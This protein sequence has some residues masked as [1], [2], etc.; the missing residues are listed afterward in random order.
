M[1]IGQALHRGFVAFSGE[2]SRE[3]AGEGIF[4]RFVPEIHCREYDSNPLEGISGEVLLKVTWKFP[5]SSVYPSEFWY[6]ALSIIPKLLHRAT[7][8][9][10]P[11]G[12]MRGDANKNCRPPSIKT[13][14]SIF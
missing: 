1:F 10:V 13:R 2:R 8:C 3:P 7:T 4:F 14:L 11:R 9:I 6:Q 12:K 5:Y